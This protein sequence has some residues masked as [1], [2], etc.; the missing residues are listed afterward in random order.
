[1]SKFSHVCQIIDR[2]NSHDLLGR[3]AARGAFLVWTHHMKNITF[4]DSFTPDGGSAFEVYENGGAS[5][6]SIWVYC[7]VIPTALNLGAGVQWHEAYDA[8]HS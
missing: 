3:S 8:A 1:M 4:L 2:P 7:S 6:V 5:F